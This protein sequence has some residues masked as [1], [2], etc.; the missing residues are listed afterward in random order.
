MI[1]DRFRLDGRVAIVTGASAGIGRGSALAF[2]DAGA[3]V[4]CA[5][6]T[7]ER[8]EEVAKEI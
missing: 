3:D 5:A 1:L 6:R 2:A 7:P 4:V 8:L